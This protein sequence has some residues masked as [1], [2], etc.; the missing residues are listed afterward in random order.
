[1]KS[2][3]T[4]EL[5]ITRGCSACR[6]AE[7]TLRHCDRIRR[8]ADLTVIDMGADGAIRPP[9]VIGG[10]TTVFEGTVVALGTPDCAELADRL[11]TLIGVRG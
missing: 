3:P 6:R 8:L 1:M 2:K 4:L 7:R 5:Y 11:E 9:G 10:P